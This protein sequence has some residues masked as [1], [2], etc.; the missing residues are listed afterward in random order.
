[1]KYLQDETCRVSC[2]GKTWV[3]D[4]DGTLVKHNG[5]KT[6]GHDTLLD[7]I[8]TL[9]SQIKEEDMV[10]I[11]TARDRKYAA[12][13]EGFLTGNGIRYN[14]IIYNAPYGERIL[15][16]DRKPSGLPMSVAIDTDRDSACRVRFE[17]D[18]GL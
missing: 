10:I 13:T 6:D 8:D 12:Q 4:L 15:I 16:N 18:E 3:L 9:L 17:V 11:V 5:Y 14:H 1:M 7:G 2:L